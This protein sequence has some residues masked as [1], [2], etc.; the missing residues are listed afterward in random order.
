[1]L[2]K[3]YNHFHLGISKG[4]AKGCLS[5]EIAVFYCTPLCD[6]PIGAAFINLSLPS[7]AAAK[8][9]VWWWLSKVSTA[10]PRFW[11]TSQLSSAE[12][13]WFGR[14]AAANMRVCPCS[15][16]C[17]KSTGRAMSRAFGLEPVCSHVK[18]SFC[19]PMAAKSRVAMPADASVLFHAPAWS[20][21]TLE[22][23]V[24]PLVR[25][26]DLTQSSSLSFCWFRPYFKWWSLPVFA[27]NT[28]LQWM[29]PKKVYNRNLHQK[30]L[31]ATQRSSQHWSLICLLCT[32]RR[33]C[34]NSTISVRPQ[35][36]D[37]TRCHQMSPDVTRC[38]QF[39]TSS[40]LRIWQNAVSAFDVD[41]HG[42]CKAWIVLLLS[43]APRFVCNSPWP[44]CPQLV[45][46]I[47]W[48][49]C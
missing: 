9:G 33:L 10:R 19:L 3:I 38:H 40:E 39:S 11:S 34:R 37:V 25:Q 16:I 49:F 24:R 42:S 29:N 47:F 26:F 22:Q 5:S 32:S 1:M 23:G 14:P 2:Q 27:F 6:Q 20:S 4:N 45:Q 46:S 12:P 21:A 30:K 31:S 7:R 48:I 36:P 44:V 41:L 28:L 15:F 43:N 17:L 13:L 18:A 35:S 8:S